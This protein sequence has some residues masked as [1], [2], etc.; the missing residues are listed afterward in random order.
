VILFVPLILGGEFQRTS[1]ASVEAVHEAV[2]LIR[3]ILSHFRVQEATLPNEE[4]CL[5]Q[6]C[7]V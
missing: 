5:Q 2:V 6:F 4:A 7:E 3:I 1:T